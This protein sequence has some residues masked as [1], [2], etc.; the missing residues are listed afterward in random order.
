M[1]QAGRLLIRVP[2]GLLNIFN[3]PNPSS[4]I[5]TLGLAKPLTE[6]VSGELRDVSA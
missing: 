4:R 2:V 6:N 3:L 1:L 5:V